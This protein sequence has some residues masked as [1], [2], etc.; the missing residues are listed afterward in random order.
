[1]G[2]LSSLFAGRTEERAADVSS[3]AGL[4][5]IVPTVAGNFVTP[6]TALSNV[7]VLRCVGIVSQS[8]ASVP[9]ILYRR[10]GRQRMRAT[11]H[12]VYSVLATAGNSEMTAYEVRESRI[13]HC[14]AWGNAFAEIQYDSNYQVRG[15]WPLAPDRV[16]VERNA[17]GRLVYTYWSDSMGQGFTL[18]AYRVLHLRYT[19]IRGV[20]GI[21][22]IKQ[23]MNA[24]GVASAAEE[25]GGRYF[26]Q[27]SRPSIILKVPTR[28]TPEAYARLRDSFSA[29]WQGL[30]N[31][32]RV[33]I[34]ED[35]VAP[36]VIG[37]PPEEAQF[38]QTRQFQVQEIARLYGVP[39]H[40]LATGESAT[41]ASAE[42]DAINFRQ[43]TLLEW[44]RRDEQKL[45]MDLLTAD[46]R[47]QGYYAEYLLDGLERATIDTRTTAYSTMIQNAIMMPNEARERENLDP[48]PGGDVLLLPLNMQQIR[49]DGTTVDPVAVPAAS[50]RPAQDPARS[51]AADVLQRWLGEVKTRL[52][53]IVANDVRQAGGRAL[54]RGG[55]AGLEEWISEKYGD[56]RSASQRMLEAVEAA[57]Q[58]ASGPADALL[59]PAELGMCI[60]EAVRTSVAQLIGGQDDGTTTDCD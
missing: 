10:D 53:S 19:V 11:E 47:R 56:W 55:R 16:G 36:E 30:E 4:R 9:L 50:P 23:A 14:M 20:L 33:N 39:L 22:P 41:F 12:A 13:A 29:N 5:S 34:L 35:G 42:Q 21:S 51:E 31:A 32:H 28:L 15:L 38:L 46:E 48:L 1:M 45:T 8:L 54:R 60:D 24:L 26:A 52:A 7:T 49:P 44:A 17:A 18:P 3:L 25:Y 59:S 37:I 27:G 43:H 2:I 6:D 57:A 40:M 58:E